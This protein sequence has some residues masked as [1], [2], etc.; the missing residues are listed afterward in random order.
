MAEIR[1]V[2]LAWET[3]DVFR[4][5]L[6]QVQAAIERMGGKNPA[7]EC[8]NDTA[9]SSRRLE[10][11]KR[12]QRIVESLLT[13]INL[14]AL[15]AAYKKSEEYGKLK[16]KSRRD[17]AARMVRIER[18]YGELPL[19]DVTSEDLEKWRVRWSTN[20]A[21]PAMGNAV[22]TALRILLRFGAMELGDNECSRLA[23]HQFLSSEKTKK[24]ERKQINA[25][26]LNAFRAQAHK[27]G[28]HTLALGRRSSFIWS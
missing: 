1:D 14:A 26:Q 13:P 16:Y 9:V 18:D 4:G 3:I 5:A 28:L 19:M 12:C 23:F 10:L 6:C 24:R 22:M 8:P 25:A 7:A 2:D 27:R 17:Y 11:R 15:I 20:G 21:H